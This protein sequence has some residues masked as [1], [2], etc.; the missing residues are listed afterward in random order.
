MNGQIMNAKAL[1]DAN[2]HP[3]DA[4]IRQGMAGVLCRC[5]TYYRVQDAIKRAIQLIASGK[6]A[7]S[8]EGVA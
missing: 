1:L 3:T 4:Q 5:G 2:P 8:E 6:T 7:S